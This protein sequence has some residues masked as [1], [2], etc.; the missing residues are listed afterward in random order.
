MSR[1]GIS[2]DAPPSPQ[3][4]APR[5]APP[6]WTWEDG[7]LTRLVIRH[8]ERLRLVVSTPVAAHVRA[9]GYSG[10]GRF[11]AREIRNR[12]WSSSFMG[13]W[14]SERAAADAL[15]AWAEGV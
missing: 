4:I 12:I 2:P 15:L 9:F 6:G 13:S 10:E 14:S 1:P 11:T 7:L 5:E 3:T 8:G